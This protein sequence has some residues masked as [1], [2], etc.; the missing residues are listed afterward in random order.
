MAR[1]RRRRFHSRKRSTRKIRWDGQV[2]AIDTILDANPNDYSWISFWVKQPASN[3]RLAPINPSVN[4]SNEPTDETL[5]RL[6][7]HFD[8]LVSVP[9]TAGV[10]PLVNIE[11]GIIPW[12]GG[13]LPEFYDF[14]IFSLAS[15]VAPPHPTFNT[16]DP[17]VWRNSFGTAGAETLRGATGGYELADWVRSMRKLPAGMGLLCVI[18]VI[19]LLEDSSVPVTILYNGS[20]RYAVKSGFTV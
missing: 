4:P 2:V 19:A 9:G 1:F 14:A 3:A 13:E 18:G 20:Q 8:M 10:A 17:W 11:T 7:S 6:F 12:Q 5:V 15:L 16:D